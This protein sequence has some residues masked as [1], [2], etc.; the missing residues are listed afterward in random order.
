MDALCEHKND[1][2]LTQANT[3]V[4]VT[5]WDPSNKDDWAAVIQENAVVN[6]GHATSMARR[7]PAGL[8][9]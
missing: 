9:T 8:R 5:D 1:T 4:E 6:L 2:D 3:R 7:F